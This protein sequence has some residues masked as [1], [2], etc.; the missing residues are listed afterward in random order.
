VL[1]VDGA[2]AAVGTGLAGSDDAVVIDADGCYVLPGAIDTHTHMDMPVGTISTV[3]DFGSGTA[4]A[5]AGGT[6][7]IVD[8]VIQQP[9]QPVGEAV[10]TWHAKLARCPPYVD[11]GFHFAVTDVTVPDALFHLAGLPAAGI[12]SFKLFM[13][14][15][16]TLMIDDRAMLSVMR[17]A[18]R[19]GALV[20]VHAENGDVVDLLIRSAVDSGNTDPIWHARTRPPVAEAEATGRA[21]A[22]ASV[23]G[24]PLYVVHVSC[25]QSLAAI[26]T[27]R[28]AAHPVFAE[29]CPQYLVCTEDDLARQGFEGAKYVFSPPAR[30][31]ADQEA[32]WRALGSGSLDAVASDH[33]PF[34]F[35]GQ[36]SIGHDDF[37]L[38]P[39]G[40]PG[41]EERVMLLH[42]LGV[43]TGRI[44]LS[45]WVE[46]VSTAPA[47]MFGLYPRKGTI[48]PG[49]DAD[50]VVFDPSRRRVLSAVDGRSRA[51]Y[52][53]YEGVAVTGAPSVVL[54]RGEPV[55]VDG[56]LVDAP[57]RGEWVA[58]ARFGEPLAPRAVAA[59]VP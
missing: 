25:V 10:A 53:L 34:L 52:S 9:G 20:L 3:D 21:I 1:V 16:G 37:S 18:A 8:F 43:R 40:A 26:T 4:A 46:L 49:A 35:H 22:L 44:S 38:I 59:A 56:E 47:R 15:R 5:A 32:L 39:N 6:T 29:T 51:D 27:A 36:K 28:A 11:V 48:A 12:T 19:A 24:C 31:V 2:V 55:V 58:R 23:A 57:P 50:L 13:A 33:C 30:T 7:C 45:R 54:V 17:V 14:Y 42:E 41:V